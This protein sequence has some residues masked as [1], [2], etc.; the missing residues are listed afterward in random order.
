MAFI[1]QSIQKEVTSQINQVGINKDNLVQNHKTLRQVRQSMKEFNHS[2]VKFT[3]K[4]KGILDQLIEDKDLNWN[5]DLNS[6]VLV[7]QRTTV[8]EMAFQVMNQVFQ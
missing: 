7:T 4:A 6:N 2:L 5:L 3:T 1:N 8:P